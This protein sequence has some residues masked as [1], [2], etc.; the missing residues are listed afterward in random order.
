VSFF[1]A[2]GGQRVGAMM[3]NRAR[4]LLAVLLVMAAHTL[5]YDHPFPLAAEPYRFLWLGLSGLIGLALGDSLL[6]QCYVMIGSRRGGL[7][8]HGDE[9]GP[10]V[11]AGAVVDHARARDPL[12]RAGDG[13]RDD[14]G[15]VHVSGVRREADRT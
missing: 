9:P 4:L 13:G 8:A 10:V 12:R 3:V 6:F 15:G 11:T 14:R 5:I 1:F 7:D 2:N